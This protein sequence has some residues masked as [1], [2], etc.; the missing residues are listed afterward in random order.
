MLEKSERE[1]IIALIHQE[2]VPAIGCTE[3]IAVALGVAKTSENLKKARAAMQAFKA[4]GGRP[5][6][7]TPNLLVVPTALQDDA[8][9]LLNREMTTEI[10]QVQTG[11]DAGG[12]PIYS[13]QTVAVSNDTKGMFELLVSKYL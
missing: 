3:P 2:V 1:Q 5:L 10:V 8:E 12:A 4:D 13:P 6:G 7:I 9:K 11:T